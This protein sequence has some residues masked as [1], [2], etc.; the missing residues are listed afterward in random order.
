MKKIV[1]TNN[2]ADMDFYIE[3]VE[4]V[5]S[6]S[7]L[8]ETKYSEIESA[9]IFNLCRSYRYQS[10]GYYVSLLAE[11]RGHRAFPNIST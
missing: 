9:R 6:K 11:A 10:T 7:Y 8:T 5:A 1:V 4:V 2:L 3:D